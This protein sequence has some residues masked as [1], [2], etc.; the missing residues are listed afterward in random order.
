MVNVITGDGG[1]KSFAIFFLFLFDKNSLFF[2]SF[3]YI[4]VLSFLT[5]VLTFGH[6]CF[7]VFP[8]LECDE[9]H[10]QKAEKG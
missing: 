3:Y 10:G 6:G 7:S 9:C 1:N 2:F 5:G 4:Y 8:F